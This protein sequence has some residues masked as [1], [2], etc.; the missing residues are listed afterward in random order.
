[1]FDNTNNICNSSKDYTLFTEKEQEELINSN[2][3]EIRKLKNIYDNLLRKEAEQQRKEAEQQRK[4]AEQQRKE[5]EQDE[6]LREIAIETKKNREDIREL[7]DRVI[8]YKAQSVAPTKTSN[9]VNCFCLNVI[10]PLVAFGIIAGG[11]YLAIRFY[12]K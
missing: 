1:M 9:K 6:I 10:I 8:A 12:H 3:E 2:S 11:I 7:H 5:V 4:K